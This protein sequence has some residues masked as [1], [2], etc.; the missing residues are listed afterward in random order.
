MSKKIKVRIKPLEEILKI[1]WVEEY[2]DIKWVGFTG[3]MTKMCWNIYT[4]KKAYSGLY[5][6][7]E[8]SFERR[9]CDEV[10]PNYNINIKI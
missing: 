1:E 5:F 2:L 4:W 9:W 6:I 10:L 7:C 8:W 3:E